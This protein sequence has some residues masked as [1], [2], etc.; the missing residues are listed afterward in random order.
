MSLDVADILNGEK[1]I[2]VALKYGYSSPTAFCRSFQ[3]IHGISP[4]QAR[5]KGVLLKTY[6]PISFKLSIKGSEELSYRI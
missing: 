1:V 6:P 2:A 3:N 5:K 4:S